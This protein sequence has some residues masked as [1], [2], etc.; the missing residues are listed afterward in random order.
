[1]TLQDHHCPWVNNCI[2]LNNY[3]YFYSFL[4][5]TCLGTFY[6]AA[7]LAPTVLKEGSLLRVGEGNYVK[8]QRPNMHKKQNNLKSSKSLRGKSLENENGNERNLIPKSARK[9]LEITEII[10]FKEIEG[11]DGIE[12]RDDRE[13][14]RGMNEIKGITGADLETQGL[15]SNDSKKNNLN[16][17]EIIFLNGTNL[18]STEQSEETRRSLLLIPTSFFTF[19]YLETKWNIP[20]Q[21]QVLRESDL[22]LA[23]IFI[24]SI[25]ISFA[26][27]ILL[28]LHTYLLLSA[29]T[30]I[31]FFLSF[32]L[33]S[34]FK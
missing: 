23:L 24:L 14:V 30:T 19:H 2:G 6:L 3:R 16:K 9:M 15:L 8:I 32:P 11:I 33:R 4:L 18:I 12:G 31:E 20:E 26:V 17:V 25:A 5:W 27:G 10:G 21:I 28:V 13:G 22:M 29:Q 34:K 7:L 1:M